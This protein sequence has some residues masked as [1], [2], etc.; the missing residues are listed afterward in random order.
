M[1]YP[2]LLLSIFQRYETCCNVRPDT[3]LNKDVKEIQLLRFQEMHVLVKFQ[4]IT[5]SLL[6]ISQQ[7]RLTTALC[8][9]PR[10]NKL[11]RSP[12]FYFSARNL[13][14]T[15]I[16]LFSSGV[17]VRMTD[18]F[19]HEQSRNGTLVNTETHLHLMY[20]CTMMW[21]VLFSVSKLKHLKYLQ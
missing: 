6:N 15:K 12:S 1:H 2:K 3:E 14:N 11:T 18:M 21:S 4:I 16:I 7:Q 8:Q 20:L 19:A 13:N 5:C 17:Y 9:D 10:E